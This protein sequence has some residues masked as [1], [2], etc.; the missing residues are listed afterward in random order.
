MLIFLKQDIQLVRV[1]N[2][3]IR[4]KV[5]HLTIEKTIM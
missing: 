2:V 5:F 1:L 3:L 4:I